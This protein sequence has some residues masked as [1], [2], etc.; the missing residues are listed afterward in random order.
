MKTQSGEGLLGDRYRV[1]D[2][3]GTGAMAEVRA[4]HDERLDRPVAIKILRPELSDAADARR[5]F[6][7][8]ARAAA[9]LSHP[10]IVGVYDVDDEA[11]RPFLVMERLPG[12]TLAD[13]LPLPEAQVIELGLQVT[14][15]LA[16][17]HD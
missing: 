15:A 6:E 4:A 13:E 14:A 1:G 12:R 3:L 9:S 5:R 16:V 8:E 7:A 2:L 11:D 17:A 10:N